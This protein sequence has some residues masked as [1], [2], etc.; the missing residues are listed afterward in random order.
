MTHD[1][2]VA[3][4]SD[5]RYYVECDEKGCGTVFGPIASE[6]EANRR[7][8]AHNADPESD[9]SGSTSGPEVPIAEG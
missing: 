4:G 2:Y 3:I 7:V 6:F 1:A 8:L 9:R 5:D